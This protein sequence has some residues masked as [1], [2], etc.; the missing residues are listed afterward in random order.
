MEIEILATVGW[1]RHNPARTPGLM[2]ESWISDGF[3]WFFAVSFVYP[4]FAV[5]ARSKQLMLMPVTV[6]FRL[7][8]DFLVSGLQGQLLRHLAKVGP[9]FP[10]NKGHEAKNN[11]GDWDFSHSGLEARLPA[12]Q[13]PMF[14]KCDALPK[15]D[16][17]EMLFFSGIYFSIF[18]SKDI[19]RQGQCLSCESV[20]DSNDFSP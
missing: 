19:Q 14:S 16:L 6:E 11:C 4:K 5:L 1:K 8:I 7:Y 9:I 10:C 2:F 12:F 17:W 20:M 15:G 18:S 13:L 3:E